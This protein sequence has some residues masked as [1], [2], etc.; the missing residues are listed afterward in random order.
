M[1]FRAR[2]ASSAPGS[3]TPPKQGDNMNHRSTFSISFLL[4]VLAASAHA[5]TW[6][7]TGALG[8]AR[9]DHTATLLANGKVLV[10]GGFQSCAPQCRAT[11][12]AELYDPA[13]GAWSSAG[14]LPAALATHAAVR[15]ADGRVLVISGFSPPSTFLRTAN[16]YDPA[17]NAWT[18]TGGPSAGR[19]YHT[20]V[21]LPNGKVL[22]TG[23]LMVVSNRLAPTNVAELYDPATGAWSLTGAMN[24]ARDA[25]TMTLLPNGKVLV[26]TGSD[27]LVAAPQLFTP[28]RSCELYDP[29]TGSWT[30]T[31]ELAVPRT[32]PAAVLLPNGKVLLAGG[33]NNNAS[34]NPTNIAELYDP[35]TGQWSGA[36]SM[37]VARD[38][39]TA[40]LLPNGKVLL[41]GGYTNGF[42]VLRSTE[43]YD[44]VGGAW[45]SGGEMN[46]V[47]SVHTATLLPSGKVLVAGGAEVYDTAMAIAGAEQFDSGA[48]AVASVSAASF[49]P[50]AAPES[51]V[52]AFGANLAPSVQAA[53]STPLPTELAGVRVHVRDALG[54]ERPA[55]LFFVSP[56]QINYLMPAGAAPGTAFINVSSGAVGV[57]EIAPTA[58]GLFSANADGQGVAAAVAF[59]LKANGAQSFEPVARLEGGRFVPLPLDLG[60]EG[61]QLF[62][63][64]YG[65]GLRLRS[66]LGA[67]RCNLGGTGGEVLFAGD[68][69]GFTGLD[70][71]NVRIPRGLIG[72][73]EIAV[74]LT[75]DGRT[76]N[77]VRIHIR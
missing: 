73:G 1:P 77:A 41:A 16:L 25:H 4:C 49:L 28:V 75:V 32:T 37:A 12:T 65:S 15:L 31:G 55:P 17:T 68:A 54:I 36:A 52:A 42:A 62:L 45:S 29:Q 56:S 38:G 13:T 71:V 50:G 67:V 27:R 59:R 8:S 72:R 19:Q 5:Q 44:P 10:V 74:E 40:T 70:Q 47:R 11:N 58:P 24:V 51:I 64:L 2:I 57:V 61:E 14:T 30:L 53:S 20:A 48:A 69:P 63:I 66:A 7:N 46:R 21:L 3:F 18:P 60:P 34:V 39:T 23:G 9:T 6:S 33:T 43:L 76:A 35:A 22:M 26:A